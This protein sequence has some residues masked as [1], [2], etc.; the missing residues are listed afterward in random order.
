M[1]LPPR[2][3]LFIHAIAAALAIAA[4]A[5]AQDSA[6]TPAEDLLAGPKVKDSELAARAKRPTLVVRNFEGDIERSGPEPG[7]D[8][9]RAMQSAGGEWALVASEAKALETVAIAR[10]AALDALLRANYQEIFR[11]QGIAARAAS[12]S[13]AARLAAVLELGQVMHAF[14]PYFDRGGFLDEFARAEGVR[15]GTVDKAREIEKRYIT[16]LVRSEQK[17][18]ADA[19]SKPSGELAIRVRLRLEHLGALIRRAIERKVELGEAEFDAFAAALNL[20][21]G[22]R[23]KVRAELAPLFLA[24]LAGK[25]TPAM[26]MQ[27][28][29]RVYAM[30]DPDQRRALLS[31]VAERRA[32]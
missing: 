30:L 31:Y 32:R 23:E 15:A 7:E 25:A 24:E 19:G 14:Q 29:S 12:P 22:M 17:R 9:L 20:D 16:A 4:A 6:G 18:E 11:L 21:G 26:R 28:F 5:H 3:P 8:A 27:A 10:A 2:P 1:P 13:A